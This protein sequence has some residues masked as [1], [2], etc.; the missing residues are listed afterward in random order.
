M[1]LTYAVRDGIVSHCGELNENGLFP[2]EEAI[3]LNKFSYSGEYQSYTWEGC[4]VKLADKIAYLGRDIED[5]IRLDFIE[6]YDL[7]ELRNIAK[8]YGEKAINTTVIT[9]N[10]IISIC[11]NSSPQNGI[12]LSDKYNSML[13]EVKEF[14]IRTIYKNKKFDI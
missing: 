12:R 10:F 13:N 5:A 8:K 1:N 4:V 9:H 3:D 6:K 11:E 14:N 2:R 7:C